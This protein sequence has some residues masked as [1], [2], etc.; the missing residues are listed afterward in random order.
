VTIELGHF[1][2]VLAFAVATVSTI[3]GFSFWRSGGRAALYVRQAAVLQFVLVA[4]AFASLIAGLGHAVAAG[5]DVRRLHHL[6]LQS[7]PE[8]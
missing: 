5:G 3:I 6:H 1:A 8:A 7:V 4:A 2:L